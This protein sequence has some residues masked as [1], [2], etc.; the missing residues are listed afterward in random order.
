MFNFPNFRFKLVEV[1]NTWVN[2]VDSSKLL[3]R[4]VRYFNTELFLAECTA[5]LIDSQT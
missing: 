4:V 3:P 1:K 2:E 5:N